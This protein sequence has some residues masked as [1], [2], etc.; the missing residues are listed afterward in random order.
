VLQGKAE[1]AN[2]GKHFYILVCGLT[3]RCASHNERAM[4]TPIMSRF[5]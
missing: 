1:V 5:P 4:A 2:N 3:G